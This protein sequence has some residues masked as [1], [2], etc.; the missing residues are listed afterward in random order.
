MSSLLLRRRLA[1][2][3][4]LA[5]LVGTERATAQAVG[6]DGTVAGTVVAAGTEAPISDVVILVQGTRLVTRSDPNGRF[7]LTGL[8]GTEVTLE[9]RRI[10]FRLATV[11]AVVGPQPVSIV[12]TVTPLELDA[13]VVTGQVGAVERRAVGNAVTTIDAS[14]ELRTSGAGTLGSLINGRAP[15]VVVTSGTGRAGTGTSLSIRGRSTLSL[16]QQP[17]IYIDGVRVSNDVNT[18]PR[19]Q[20]GLVVSRLDDIAPEDI[21]SIE[22]IKGPAAGTLYGTEAANG[23]VQIIT[24]KGGAGAPSMT[25][26]VR[27]GAQWFQNAEN[28]MATNYARDASG[29]IVTWNA[30]RAEEARGTPLFKTGSLQGYAVNLR[31]GRRD[32]S[33]YLAS[34]YDRDSGIEPNNRIGRYTGHAN[35][36]VAPSER[37]DVTTSLHVVKGKSLLGA[38]YGL[39]RFF[40]AQYGSPLAASGPTRG[41]FLAPPEALDAYLLNSQAINRF[42]G[43]VQVNHRPFQWFA[44]RLTVGFDQT[45]ED[46]QALRNFLSPQFAPFFSPV[47]ALGGINQ[48]LREVSYVTADYSGTAT[49]LLRPQLKSAF[50]MGAQFYRR[51]TDLTQITASQFPAPDLTT[52]VAAAIRT[53][54]QDFVSNTTLG[55]FVQEQLAW[56]DRVFVTGAL[57]VDNNSA[58]GSDVKLATYPKLSA[59]WVVSDEGFWGVGAVDQLRLRAAYGRSGQQPEAFAALQTYSPST[60]PNDRPILTPQFPGNPGLKPERGEEIEAGFEAS[61]LRRIGIDFTYFSKHTRDA[62]LQRASA[63]SGG[64]PNPQFVNIGLVSNRGFELA[65]NANA[66]TRRNI[67]WDIGASVA[68]T[69]DRIED[70]GGLPFITVGLPFHRNQVGFPIGGFFTKVVTSADYDPATKRAINAMCDGGVDNRPGGAPVPCATA[71]MLFYGTITPKMSGA[72]TSALALGRWVK[73]NALADFRQ[74]NKLFNADLFNRCISFGVCEAIVS[75][76]SADPREL[77]TYQNGGSLTVSDAFIGNASFWRLRE[78]SATL[79]GPEKWARYLN[80]SAVTLTLAGRNLH[81]WTKYPG[82]DPESRSPLGLQ[83]IAFDQAVTP[84]LAQFVS[85]FSIT[86]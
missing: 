32:L 70:M 51:R 38:D 24:K 41:F 79:T 76:E 4:A 30:V 59:S 29:N 20:G 17:L 48:D 82:L 13:V 85:T 34:S 26:S 73:L 23:V 6:G 33:Y 72:V 62:I 56:R 16:S 10:G 55:M 15:G 58:F 61:L 39:G 54:T 35:L 57:R 9:A 66:F 67:A 14:N 49:N 65:V 28:R 18:G 77:Y 40:N 19:T 46:N 5:L 31:G 74:G 64:F 84:T 81:T 12:L 78:V 71:P 80:A 69:T 52:A 1:V 21:E 83:N 44:H 37:Y 75:P 63:P 86:F 50:S 68:T 45:A 42:T 7:R 60:G 3:I 47:D 22:I 8:T 27:H 25:A 11:R 53:G 43:S 2:F 36:T